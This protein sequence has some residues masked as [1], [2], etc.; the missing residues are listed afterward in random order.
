MLRLIGELVKVDEA[1]T[2]VGR[3]PQGWRA[4]LSRA[5]GVRAVLRGLVPGF[6][7]YNEPR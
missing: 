5:R 4:R 1:E 3:N 7:V 6:T 2:R